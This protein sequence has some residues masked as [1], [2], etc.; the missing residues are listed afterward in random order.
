MLRVAHAVLGL[1]LLTSCGARA[2]PDSM[3]QPTPL[4]PSLADTVLESA[5]RGLEWHLNLPAP[6]CLLFEVGD[7][8]REPDT[9]F[10]GRLTL[11]HPVL[12]HRAC[13]RT[14]GSMVRAVDSLGRDIGPKRPAGYVDPYHI[15]ITPPVALNEKR[16]VVR[17]EASQ[18]TRGWLFYCEVAV[19]EPTRATC[20]PTVEW[21]S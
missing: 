1:L 2:K 3:R 20:G 16:A 13:P 6:Y 5:L 17:L 18:G 12:P 8:W 7:T 9:A 14:Y 19:A 21:V 11:E 15:R 4:A 10:L